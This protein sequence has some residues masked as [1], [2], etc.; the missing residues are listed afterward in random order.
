[1]RWEYDSELVAPLA[2]FFV[3][4][5]QLDYISHGELQEGRAID[6]QMWS[7][8][9]HDLVQEQFANAISESDPKRYRGLLVARL[10]AQVRGLALVAFKCEVAPRFAVLEDLVVQRDYRGVG[11]G[12]ALVDCVRH[13]CIARKCERLFLESGVRNTRAHE[14]F[15]TRGFRTVS[16]V[17]VRDL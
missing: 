3:E 14:F 2:S 5:V 17:F 1:M 16:T 11:I 8:R 12:R 4:N 6:E 9:L 15:V 7:Q 10:E 13:E